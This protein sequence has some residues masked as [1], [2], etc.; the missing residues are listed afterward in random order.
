MIDFYFDQ[1]FSKFNP[2]DVQ[3]KKEIAREM[4]NIIG[5]ISNKIEQAHYLQILAG[6]LEVDESIL[7]ETL[8]KSKITKSPYLPSDDKSGK[9]KTTDKKTQL[10][11]RLVSFVIICPELFGDI[12]PRIKD[13]LI[14]TDS[15]LKKIIDLIINGCG[16]ERIT[17]QGLKIIKEN[18]DPESSAKWDLLA[19]KAE[20]EIERGVD[21][22][23]EVKI[24]LNELEKININEARKN[25]EADLKKATRENDQEACKLLLGEI[26]KLDKRRNEI[27]E[28]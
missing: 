13:G 5:K 15:T 14:I 9:I 6:R 2:K 22:G 1:A 4:L 23:E 11:E 7:R 25:L 27:D 16:K 28:N 24:C 21:A 10:Q 18:S 17:A 3:G 12:V 8:R 20:M 26:D 19:M